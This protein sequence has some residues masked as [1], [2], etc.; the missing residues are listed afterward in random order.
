M[1]ALAQRL[2]VAVFQDFKLGGAFAFE[3][4]DGAFF[5]VDFAEGFEKFTVVGDGVLVNG[6]DDVAFLRF[7]CWRRGRVCPHG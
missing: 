2:F 4:D 6:G 1:L 7:R 5:G 3:V